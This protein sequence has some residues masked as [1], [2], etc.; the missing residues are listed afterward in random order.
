MGSPAA[1]VVF[2]PAGAPQLARTPGMS[3]GI[4]SAAQGAYSTSQLLLDITQ[5]A[6]VAS[7]AY[8]GGGPRA[9]HP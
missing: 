8:P 6:R 3:V 5:G 4:M 1:V 2:I 9:A 7:S